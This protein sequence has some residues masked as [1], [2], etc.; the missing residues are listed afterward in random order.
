MNRVRRVNKACVIWILEL[1]KTAG[2][3]KASVRERTVDEWRELRFNF[4]WLNINNLSI[5]LRRRIRHCSLASCRSYLSMNRIEKC[6]FFFIFFCNER[7][8]VRVQKAINEIPE[9]PSWS[10]AVLSRCW[11]TFQFAQLTL[12]TGWGEL[13]LAALKI[14]QYLT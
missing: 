12:V 3:C 6:E 14:Y 8:F 11:P 7:F 4:W 13:S 2:K 1:R 5:D 10:S 9:C